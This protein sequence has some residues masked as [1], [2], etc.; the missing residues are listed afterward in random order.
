VR[1]HV[2]FVESISPSPTVLTYSAVTAE[3]IAQ[4]YD[5]GIEW[6]KVSQGFVIT[7]INPR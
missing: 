7:E 5:I 1:F 2:E 3:G 6:S 4:M